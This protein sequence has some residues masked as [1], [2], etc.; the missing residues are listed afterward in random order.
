MQPRI[1]V[2]TLAVADL[3]HQENPNSKIVFVADVTAWLELDN[4][5]K[6][7][8]LDVDIY[9]AMRVLDDQVPN[10]V[11]SA[12]PIAIA[13]ATPAMLPTPTVDASAVA[14]A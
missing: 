11:L 3:F 13:V 4:Q 12:S 14:T 7:A 2:I 6:W 1:H 5:T 10:L 9:E 8:D